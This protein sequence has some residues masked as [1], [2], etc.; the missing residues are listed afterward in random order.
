MNKNTFQ[1][2]AVGI[3]IPT[4]AALSTIAF[5]K[6]ITKFGYTFSAGIQNK[7]V[8]PAIAAVHAIATI[9]FFKYSVK[10]SLNEPIIDL[11]LAGLQTTAIM[12]VLVNNPLKNWQITPL[13]CSLIYISTQISLFAVGMILSTYEA[14]NKA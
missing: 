6:A 11:Q 10:Y 13:G 7:A 3:G 5:E 14:L 8:I 1:E 12:L 4:I 2:F 9:V